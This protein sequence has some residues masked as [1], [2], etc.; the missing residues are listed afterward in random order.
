MIHVNVG[1]H[2]LTTPMSFAPLGLAWLNQTRINTSRVHVR[3][4]QFGRRGRYRGAEMGNKIL[5][6]RSAEPLE[7]GPAPAAPRG[8]SMVGFPFIAVTFDRQFTVP[9]PPGLSGFAAP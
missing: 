3:T 1:F 7:T 9:P 8:F 5:Q 6:F 4:W 2:V